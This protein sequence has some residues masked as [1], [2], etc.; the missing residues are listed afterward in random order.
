VSADSWYPIASATKLAIG[1]L[2]LRL[3]GD[4]VVALDEPVVGTDAQPDETAPSRTLRTLLGHLAGL[5]LEVPH[6]ADEYGTPFLR[7]AIDRALTVIA[8]TDSPSLRYSNAGY[9]LIG[10]IGLGLGY[11]APVSTLMKWFP[12]RPGM[13]TGMA[14][15]GFG[16]G[17]LI[18]SPLAEELMNH[19]KATSPYPGAGASDCVGRGEAERSSRFCTHDGG[20]P[21]GTCRAVLAGAC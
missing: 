6:R 16:G 5:P 18:G 11:I 21:R 14:I 10:G 13:A 15:M 2:S 9:G 1:L 20:A 3:V 17:A 12:D 4:G 7:G 8:S 19:F